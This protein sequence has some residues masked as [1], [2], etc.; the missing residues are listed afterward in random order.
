MLLV[1]LSCHRENPA[2]QDAGPDS[3]TKVKTRLVS[4]EGLLYV[5]FWF[6]NVVSATVVTKSLDGVHRDGADYTNV[7]GSDGMYKARGSF[8]GKQ[9]SK[10]VFD[11][12]FGHLKT[13]SQFCHAK[14]GLFSFLCNDTGLRS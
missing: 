5:P 11:P 1:F 7:E 8:A 10:Q 2:A 14:I 9:E 6:T 12:C 3:R 4:T 13:A